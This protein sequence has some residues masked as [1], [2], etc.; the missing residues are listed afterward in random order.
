[1]HAFTP[2]EDTMSK[3]PFIRKPSSLSDYSESSFDEPGGDDDDLQ[4]LGKHTLNI[5]CEV[6]KIKYF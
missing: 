4:G 6:F 1:M 2:T 3:A 5:Y